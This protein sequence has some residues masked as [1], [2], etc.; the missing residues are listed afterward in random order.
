MGSSWW[1][2]PTVFKSLVGLFLLLR[3]ETIINSQQSC[4]SRLIGKMS[5]ACP[6]MGG[7]QVQYTVVTEASTFFLLHLMIAC[8]WLDNRKNFWSVI[9]AWL[10]KMI[11][12]SLLSRTDTFDPISKFFSVIFM[13]MNALLV[14]ICYASVFFSC[15]YNFVS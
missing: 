2:F 7:P 6:A 9:Q 13:Q 5:S 3:I 4:H 10:L 11:N 8:Q 12:H 1:V 15:E 14:W